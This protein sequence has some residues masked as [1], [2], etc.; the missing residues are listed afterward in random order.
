[1]F[2][3][4]NHHFLVRKKTKN[5]NAKTMLKSSTNSISLAHEA[6]AGYLAVALSHLTLTFLFK[7]LNFLDKL[8][9]KCLISIYYFV[10]H[11]H[12]PTDT[13]T[14]SI[15]SCF[16]I[17]NSEFYSVKFVNQAES[18]HEGFTG[19]PRTFKPRNL[20]ILSLLNIYLPWF[21]T[22]VLSVSDHLM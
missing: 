16:F 21:C 2:K 6:V 1:M 3:N 9:V 18:P 14:D 10:G 7:I 19:S 8:L 5:F 17:R 13:L 15:Q 11:T 12:R 22:F 20:I 4:L